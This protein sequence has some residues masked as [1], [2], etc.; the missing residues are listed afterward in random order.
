MFFAFKF[1][2]STRGCAAT[3]FNCSIKQMNRN[4]KLEGDHSPANNQLENPI[5]INAVGNPNFKINLTV[6]R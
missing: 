5:K 6:L 4:I 2:K 3:Q 1:Y